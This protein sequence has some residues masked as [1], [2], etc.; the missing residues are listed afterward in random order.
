MA[1]TMEL[2]SGYDRRKNPP[3][4]TFRRMT[5]SEAKR[6]RPGDRHPILANDGTARLVT[7]NGGVKTWK[8]SPERV[9]VPVKHGMY[10]YAK[11]SNIG[12]TGEVDLL[13]VQVDG[14]DIL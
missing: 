7:I 9:E 6:L 5:T 4:A 1:T 3:T 10:E 13:L 2:K 8:R 11:A 12:E 14:P